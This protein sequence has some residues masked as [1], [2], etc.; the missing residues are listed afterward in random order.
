MMNLR[1]LLC[2]TIFVLSACA[3]PS[4]PVND[5]AVADGEEGKSL[6]EAREEAWAEIDHAACEAAGGEV[7]PAGMLGMPRCVIPY[8]DAGAICADNDDCAGKCLG[9]DDVTDYSASPGE[10]QGRCEADD[11]P[12]GCYAEIID[13]S[14][15]PALCVD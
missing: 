7:R 15:G 1:I 13:G 11:S 3:A 2:C 6:E 12:F 8:A 9:S 5:E 4:S 10:M 14:A